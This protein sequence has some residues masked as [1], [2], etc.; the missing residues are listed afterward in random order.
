MK[1]K[2]YRWGDRGESGIAPRFIGIIGDPIAH[3]L[4]PAM[5]NAAFQKAGLPFVYL[6]FHVTARQLP[7][8]IKAVRGQSR[9]GAIGVESGISPRFKRGSGLASPNEST[10]SGFNVTIPHKEK[11]MRYLDSVSPEARAIGAVNTVVIRNNKLLGF[12]TDT[13]GYLRS[14]TTETGF[15]PRGKRVLIL[16]A[17]GAARAVI[18]AL[19]QAGAKEITVS[20]QIP[21]KAQ[22]LV[23]EFRKR[24]KQVRI[25]GVE[26]KTADLLVNATPVGLNGTR[27]KNLPIEELPRRAIV[28]DLVYHPA[29]TPL[30]KEAKRRGFKIHSGLGM[31]LGQG[32][33]SFQLWT[34]KRPDPGVMKKAL[35]DALR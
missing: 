21:G 9:W 6:P 17:G 4:S 13:P 24:F 3:S 28:S 26:I 27:F 8:F 20:D 35:L 18:F 22:R 12:N 29:M 19:A 30:L 16:G 1:H 32:A 7:R 5:H 2:K 15:R 31:L 11:V 33:L 34:G 23:K 10:L 25:G 14:L